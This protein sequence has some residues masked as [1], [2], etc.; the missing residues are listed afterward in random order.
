M[1]IENC[2]SL[3]LSEDCQNGDNLIWRDGMQLC[4]NCYEEYSRYEYI[5]HGMLI[6]ALKLYRRQ[7]ACKIDRISELEYRLKQ[8]ICIEAHEQVKQLYISKDKIKNKLNEITDEY[9]NKILSNEKLSLE[10]ININTQRYNAMRIVLEEL[11]E[12]E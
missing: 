5:Q 2:C 9:H 10:N 7:L 8:K 3:C 1:K 6:N 12:E 4:K 11:L